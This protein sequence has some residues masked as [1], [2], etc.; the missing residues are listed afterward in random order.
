MGMIDDVVL[1]LYD[2][3]DGHADLAAYGDD[4]QVFLGPPLDRSAPIEVLIGSWGEAAEDDGTRLSQQWAT[5]GGGGQ[6]DK[7]VVVPWCVWV[8]G[9][10][11][12]MR[13]RLITAGAVF[14]IIDS[15]LTVQDPLGLPAVLCGGVEVREAGVWLGQTS[16]GAAAAIRATATA[17]AR[18]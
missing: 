11:T 12:E 10:E 18:E 1:A 9:G 7:I 3:V 2:L 17:T 8:I 16:T 14:A 6:R 15:L 5:M 13:D 4:L